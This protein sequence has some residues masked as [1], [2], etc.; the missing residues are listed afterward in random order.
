MVEEEEEISGR[1]RG[2][3]RGGVNLPAISRISVQFWIRATQSFI[4]PESFSMALAHL[5]MISVTALRIEGES[6]TRRPISVSSILPMWKSSI[7]LSRR[8]AEGLRWYLKW[9][10]LV[11]CT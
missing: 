4:S 7:D 3:G 5:E 11:T 1:G 6:R 9:R 8:V 10:H 2:G